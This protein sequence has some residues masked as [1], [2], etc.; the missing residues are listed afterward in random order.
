MNG[1]ILVKPIEITREELVLAPDG[2]VLKG[3]P[4]GR[5]PGD[6]S[7]VVTVGVPKVENDRSQQQETL[8]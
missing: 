1:P 6:P 7:P 2:T 5:G 4:G 3:G 8:T